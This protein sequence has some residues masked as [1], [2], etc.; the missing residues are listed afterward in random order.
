[1]RKML[2]I[3]SATIISLIFSATLFGQDTASVNWSLQKTQSA[4][5]SGS[6]QGFDETFDSLQV[7]YDA[8]AVF[9]TLTLTDIQKFKPDG[10]NYI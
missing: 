1:M 9:D 5:T 2:T 7:A 3:F 10:R 8:S 6:I 4:V